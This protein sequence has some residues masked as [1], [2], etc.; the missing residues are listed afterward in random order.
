M[1]HGCSYISV[2]IAMYCLIQLYVAVSEYLAPQKPLLK[3]F[4]IKAVG[5]FE[6][7]RREDGADASQSSLHSGKPHSYQ[8]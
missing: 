6:P 5:R 3:L 8:S 2:T 4:A 1:S 7:S